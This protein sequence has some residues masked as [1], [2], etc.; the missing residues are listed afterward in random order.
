MDLLAPGGRDPNE[1]TDAEDA[2]E[3]GASEEG[4]FWDDV[5]TEIVSSIPQ[6]WDTSCATAACFKAEQGTSQAAPHVAGAFAV[7]RALDPTYSQTDTSSLLQLL[8]RTGKQIVNPFNS[9]VREPDSSA[10]SRRADH[11][12]HRAG[13][14]WLQDA[15]K[16]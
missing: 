15:E 1:R 10:G 13:R 5:G 9:A 2:Q 3:G 11:D 8:Q 14:R 16:R 12:T 6:A 7:L 4:A